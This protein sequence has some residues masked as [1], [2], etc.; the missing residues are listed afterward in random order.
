MEKKIIKTDAQ[1]ASI[2]I[3]PKKADPMKPESLFNPDRKISLWISLLLCVLIIAI[4][5]LTPPQIMLSI[6]FIL[7]VLI[8]GWYNGLRWALLLSVALPVARFLI[9][10]YLEPFWHIEYNLINAI[11]RVFVLSL[12]SFFSARLSDSVRHLQ[13]KVKELESFLPIC[14]NCKKIRDNNQ[15]WQP[16]EKYISEHSDTQFTHGVCPDC[17]KLLYGD[18]IKK[19]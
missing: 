9:A 17:M 2:Y 15:E 1:A 3:F 19:P 4:D 7:P 6:F 8:A 18:L 13:H 14:A 16:L 12:V 11:D 10:T 5:L